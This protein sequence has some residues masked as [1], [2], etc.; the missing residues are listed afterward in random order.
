M[1]FAFHLEGKGDVSV[2][3]VYGLLDLIASFGGLA[4]GLVLFLYIFVGTYA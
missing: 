3:R 4:L 1:N 2:R